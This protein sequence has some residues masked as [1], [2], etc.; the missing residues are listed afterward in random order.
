M[1][2]T[3]MRRRRPP[4]CGGRLGLLPVLL[5]AA[6]SGPALEIADAEAVAE[7]PP[8][9]ETRWTALTELFV[10]Y[11]PLIEGVTS[12]F[13]IHFTDLSTPTAGMARTAQHWNSTLPKPATP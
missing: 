13:A 2:L 9:V 4:R 5:L 12:R 10:E 11:P 3:T 8:V 6:C 7:T 1:T